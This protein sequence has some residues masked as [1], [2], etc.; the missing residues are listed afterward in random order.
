MLSRTLGVMFKVKQL[1]RKNYLPVLL[2]HIMVF[3]VHYNSYEV[4]RAQSL[5]V[6]KRYQNIEVTSI[7]KVLGVPIKLLSSFS[8]YSE[9]T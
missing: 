2:M 6:S 8:L 5:K 7:N 9:I 1:I 3:L 4:I